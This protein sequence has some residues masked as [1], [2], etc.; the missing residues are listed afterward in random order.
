MLTVDRDAICFLAVK[1]TFYLNHASS[2]A[3]QTAFLF[4]SRHRDQDS[5]NFK[6]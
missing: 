2:M 5:T 6:F 1:L 4:S 3:K